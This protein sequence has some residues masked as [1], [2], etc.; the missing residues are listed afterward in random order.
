LENNKLRSPIQFEVDFRRRNNPISNCK[1]GRLTFYPPRFF[2]LSNQGFLS[3]TLVPLGAVTLFESFEEPA[4]WVHGQP[5]SL[6]NSLESNLRNSEN[7]LETGGFDL[8]PADYQSSPG[9]FVQP[10]LQTGFKPWGMYDHIIRYGRVLPLFE[11]ENQ[12]ALLKV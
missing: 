6:E 9:F 3:E 12:D 2:Y 5:L 8:Q 7:Q 10:L 11:Y 4:E 1:S